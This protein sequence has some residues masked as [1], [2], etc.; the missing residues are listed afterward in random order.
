MLHSRRGTQNK[1]V[2]SRIPLP[3]KTVGQSE[4]EGSDCACDAGL[5]K[6]FLCMPV[7][8][9]SITIS[10]RKRSARI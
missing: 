1:V 2:S 3:C 5:L 4:T 6:I 7:C 10:R 9:P 8:A